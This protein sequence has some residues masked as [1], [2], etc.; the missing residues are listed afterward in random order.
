[1]KKLVVVGVVAGVAVAANLLA[2][3]R[4]QPESSD[5]VEARKAAKRREMFEKMQAGMAA[6]P[7]DFPPVV[8]FNNV[9]AI[10]ENSDRILELLEQDRSAGQKRGD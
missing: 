6:M 9:A 5:E 7:D 8:M 3:K 1:M 4:Q 10:R 2:K